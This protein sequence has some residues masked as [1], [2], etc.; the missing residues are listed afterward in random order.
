VAGINQFDEPE[1]PLLMKWCCHAGVKR[2]PL[3]VW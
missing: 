2:R 3:H 1:T